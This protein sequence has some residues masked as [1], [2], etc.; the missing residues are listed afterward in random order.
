MKGASLLP[1]PY[2]EVHVPHV[3]GTA[4]EG[5]HYSHSCVRPD[6]RIGFF[7]RFPASSKFPDLDGRRTELPHYVNPHLARGWATVGVEMLGTGDCPVLAND[8]TAPDR[9]RTSLL[10]RMDGQE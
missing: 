2:Y 6:T 4:G 3:H 7:P 5:K 1:F 10:D 8:P 9:L